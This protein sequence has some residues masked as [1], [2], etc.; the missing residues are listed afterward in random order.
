MSEAHSSSNGTLVKVLALI[1]FFVSIVLVLM[2]VVETIKNAPSAFSSLATVAQNIDSY[3]PVKSITITSGKAVVNASE[4]FQINWTDVK[5]DSGEYHFTYTCTDGV[6]LLV[7]NA[8]GALTQIPCT[9]TLNLPATV[10]G[11]FLSID[12]KAMRFTDV[13]LH[14]SFINKKT[15]TELKGDLTI[16][17]V[18][19]TI[20][21]KEKITVDTP[22]AKD[23]P[24]TELPKATPVSSVTYPLSNPNGFTDL[25]VTT[26]GSGVLRNGVFAFTTAFDRD[27]ENAVQFDIKNIGTKTSS[28]W[29]FTTK[30]PS[31]ETYTSD[32][33]T[34]L[35]PHEH[36]TFTLG[37]GL[38]SDRDTKVKITTTVDTAQDT[39]STNDTS[40]V[41]VTVKN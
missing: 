11:L 18:N 28:T 3:R 22:V 7:K 37:F 36:V 2:F 14:V 41:N 25:K 29:T 23:E 26:L 1:G 4:S 20:A 21:T 40:S 16:T 39:N 38:G 27:L 31:G 33:Q 5:Q 19:A 13:P 6:S 10:H 12:S 9:Q 17:V 32:A 8:D 34:A 30:L 35:Q 15:R 24:K